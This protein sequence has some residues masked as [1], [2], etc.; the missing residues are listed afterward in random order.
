MK[1]RV[2]YCI[3]P[4]R[5]RPASPVWCAYHVTKSGACAMHPFMAS[6]NLATLCDRLAQKAAIRRLQNAR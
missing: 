3:P 2:R 6:N 1:I 5:W 4:W